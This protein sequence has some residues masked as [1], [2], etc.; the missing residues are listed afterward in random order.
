M[1]FVLPEIVPLQRLQV[2]F[3]NAVTIFEL[4]APLPMSDGVFPFGAITP[5]FASSL[6]A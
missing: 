3:F 1:H 5:P 2:R 6:G 4:P